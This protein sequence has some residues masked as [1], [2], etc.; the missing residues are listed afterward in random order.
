MKPTFFSRVFHVTEFIWHTFRL[1]ATLQNCVQY[2]FLEW[3]IIYNNK[4]SKNI[5]MKWNLHC[6]NQEDFISYLIVI[7]EPFKNIINICT[8]PVLAATWS[9]CSLCFHL[10]HSNTH[11]SLFVSS[12]IVFFPPSSSHLHHHHHPSTPPSITF[13]FFIV[14]SSF[15]RLLFLRVS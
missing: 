1:Q 13:F 10:L 6:G 14:S 5:T 8:H 11:P 9:G 12:C 4:Q 3:N 15:F 2:S 7:Y